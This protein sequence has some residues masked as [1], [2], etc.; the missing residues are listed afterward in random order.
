MSQPLPYGNFKWVEADSVI[1]KRKGV[2]HIYEVDLEYPE[3]LH[4]LHNDPCAPEKTRVTDDMLSDYCREI[5]DKFNISSSNVTKLITTLSDKENYVLHEEN[6]KLYLSLGL[7]LKRIH[8][9]L[10]FSEKPWLKPYIDFNTEKR[11]NAKNESEKDFFKLMNNSVFGKTMENVRKRCN[12]KLE[13]DRDH[14]LK[15]AAKPEYSGCKIINENLVVVQMKHRFIKFDKPSYAGMCILDLSKVL[16]YDFHYNFIKAKYGD[17]VQL[18]FTDTDS[19]FYQI[20]TDDVYV[21]LDN[22]RYLFDNSDYSK[23]S[24]FYFDF[25]KKSNR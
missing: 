15:Q 24:K 19:L 4:D 2:G 9:V 14:L 22:Y 13:T 16:M 3:E 25:N 10:E 11:K 6:L 18:L 17:L 12:I 1:P 23:S 7:K 5:K 8:R 21:D 20:R